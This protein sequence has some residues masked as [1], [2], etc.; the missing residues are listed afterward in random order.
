ML[1]AGPYQ[2]PHVGLIQ[3]AG[4][5]PL[6]RPTLRSSCAAD[7]YTIFS[8]KHA[9]YRKPMHFVPKFTKVRHRRFTG[10]LI[11]PAYVA[12]DVALS[13]CS[14]RPPAACSALLRTHPH[15]DHAPRQPARLLGSHTAR[16]CEA[17][18]G[19][20]VGEGEASPGRQAA[21]A[22][23]GGGCFASTWP[24]IR[25]RAGASC[26]SCSSDSYRPAFA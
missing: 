23:V 2:P 8:R 9:R 4:A 6:P 5:D 15:P 17:R 10:P 13:P 1:P 21:H 3:G 12:D 14:V 20:P 11:S 25:W 16:L 18:R 7:K 26:W 24:P 19:G 22:G